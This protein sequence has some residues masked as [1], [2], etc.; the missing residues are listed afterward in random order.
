MGKLHGM[1]KRLIGN[2][3]MRYA[4]HTPEHRGKFRLLSTLD[5]MCGP[6]Q[7]RSH[8]DLS[9]SVFV[10][11]LMDVSYFRAPPLVSDPRAVIDWLPRRLVEELQPGELFVDIGANIGFLSLLAARRVGAQ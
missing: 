8:D 6:F 2:L 3:A 5:R 9:L 1:I 10:S 11:S 7:L 4:V